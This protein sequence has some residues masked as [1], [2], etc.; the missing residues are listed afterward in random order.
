MKDDIIR[1][2]SEKLEAMTAEAARLERAL[3]DEQSAH[4]IK[5]SELEEKL[6]EAAIA[7]MRSVDEEGGE[8]SPNYSSHTFKHQAAASAEPT[9][10]LN[11]GEGNKESLFDHLGIA[12]RSRSADADVYGY[13]QGAELAPQVAL[14]APVIADTM[15]QL[16]KSRRPQR[17]IDASVIVTHKGDF[18]EINEVEMQRQSLRRRM[19]K[20]SKASDAIESTAKA[21]LNIVALEDV[22]HGGGSNQPQRLALGVATASSPAPAAGAAFATASRRGSVPAAPTGRRSATSSAAEEPLPIDLF[23]ESQQ[24]ADF[25]SNVT[26]AITTLPSNIC[27]DF[28]AEIMRQ[29]SCVG[30]GLAV[31][32][33]AIAILSVG[34]SESNLFLQAAESLQ[35]V[36]RVQRVQLYEIHWDS[37]SLVPIVDGCVRERDELGVSQRIPIGQGYAGKCVHMGPQIVNF[38]ASLGQDFQ[39]SDRGEG[40]VA[41]TMLALP[42]GLPGQPPVMVANLV[43]K[44]LPL[45]APQQQQLEA[46]LKGNTDGA[47]FGS[48]PKQRSAPP[49]ADKPPFSEGDVVV[50]MAVAYYVAK[51]AMKCRLA[52][53]MARLRSGMM[54]RACALGGAGVGGESVL[55][56]VRSQELCAAI[57]SDMRAA[58]NWT[59]FDMMLV[60]PGPPILLGKGYGLESCVQNETGDLNSWAKSSLIVHVVRDDVSTLAPTAQAIT[61]LGTPNRLV[62]KPVS[63]ASLSQFQAQL[64][65][66]LL[67]QNFR[68]PATLETKGLL[69]TQSHLL[70][71]IVCVTVS[72]GVVPTEV[73]TDYA[74]IENV[75]HLGTGTANIVNAKQA[76]DSNGKVET[77]PLTDVEEVVRYACSDSARGLAQCSVQGQA[78]I[79]SCEDPGSNNWT[80]RYVDSRFNPNTRIFARMDASSPGI[81]AVS[82]PLTAGSSNGRQCVFMPVFG[83]GG[84]P[85]AILRAEKNVTVQ[86]VGMNGNHKSHFSDDEIDALHSVSQHC[87]SILQ[88][89]GDAFFFCSCDHNCSQ[90]SCMRLYEIAKKTLQV[91]ALMIFYGLQL[92][93]NGKGVLAPELTPM[94]RSSAAAADDISGTFN[95]VTPAW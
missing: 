38:P 48:L 49:N 92:I 72:E 15:Q 66:Q 37:R 35:R 63:E 30:A 88:V 74:V 44:L 81:A 85:I 24:R 46:M 33:E 32:S 47:A 62:T 20:P 51:K 3:E 86:A 13:A 45:G 60:I 53:S 80:L 36:C 34:D 87:G 25:I 21:L 41:A 78:L 68:R 19:A 1:S 58:A 82:R 26:A 54:A 6:T 10:T 31:A 39:P 11:L 67:P 50:G 18:A 40:A 28:V 65:T 94:K 14:V 84:A 27:Q 89:T 7:R 90:A 56:S 75:D 9:F 77:L 16:Q 55:S 22:S 93:R 76:F 43:N 17:P 57:M 42:I 79:S 8:M 83:A 23:L 91:C 69:Q 61:Q 2:L 4:E 5:L 64:A 70:N 52:G 29:V 95:V 12:A 71:Q 59:C 73:G